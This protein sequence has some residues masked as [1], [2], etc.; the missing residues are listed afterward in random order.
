MCLPRV[1][2]H[3]QCD[4]RNLVAVNGHVE[5]CSHHVD[6]GTNAEEQMGPVS[7]KDGKKVLDILQSCRTGPRWSSCPKW[8]KMED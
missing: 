1:S 5:G 8:L 7:S 2:I 4:C 3:K 6:L